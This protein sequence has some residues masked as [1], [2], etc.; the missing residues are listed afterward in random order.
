MFIGV[1]FGGCTMM[2]EREARRVRQTWHV[3]SENGGGAGSLSDQN[4]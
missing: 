2:R 3:K 1:A 4:G